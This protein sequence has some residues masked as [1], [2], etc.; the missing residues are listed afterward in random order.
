MR[1]ALLSSL[2]PPFAIGGAEQVAS[3]LARAL[4]ALGHDVD[5]ISTCDRRE[6]GGASYRV[7]QWQGIRVWRVAPWNLYSRFAKEREQPG[8][9]ARAAWHAVDLWNPSVFGPLGKILDQV[10]PEV[11]NTHNIDGLSP[12]VWQAARKHTPA[13]VHTLHD[14][15]LLCPRATMRRADGTACERLCRT[16][17]LYAQYHRWFASQVRVLVAPSQA[18]AEMHRQAGWRGPAIEIVRNGVDVPPVRPPDIAPAD[19]LR[20]VFMSRLE[21]E[22]GC[23]TLLSVIPRCG[24][25]RFHVAG[26]GPYQERFLQPAANLT[27]HGF[28]TGNDKHELLLNAD[29]FLQL[30]ECRENAPLGLIEAKRYGL[31]LL[32]A[33][34]GGIPEQVGEAGTLIPPADPEC[35]RQT[36][37]ALSQRKQAIRDG[38]SERIRNAAGY[39]TREMAAEYLRVFRSALG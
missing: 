10:R 34:I 35:L 5:V 29:V 21:R 24:E 1:V 28:V 18:I 20:A 16:C 38:R 22:K 32:G 7:D 4:A 2:F 37:E 12:A 9:L 27:W 14:Y 26:R 25:I 11:I 39:G 33:D 15:H 31:Y 30:S 6:L 8:R 3:D 13:I 17:S 23:E 36:L 19:P